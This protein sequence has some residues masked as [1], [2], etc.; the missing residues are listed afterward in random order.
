MSGTEKSRDANPVPIGEVIGGVLKQLGLTQQLEQVRL[1]SDWPLIVGE[2]IARHS[3]PVKI[4]DGKLSLLVSDS[5]W[6]YE[7]GSMQAGVLIRKI[8]AH[9][10]KPLVKR[11]DVKVG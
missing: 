1:T 3:R 2:Q 4:E 11:L 10:G 5:T 9:L 7:L 8:N 6:K